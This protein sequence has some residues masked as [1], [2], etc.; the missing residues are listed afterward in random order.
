MSITIEKSP[1]IREDHEF[2][3]QVTAATRAALRQVHWSAGQLYMEVQSLPDGFAL[4]DEW[5]RA[6]LGW[7]VNRLREAKHGLIM[8]GLY[9]WED[10]HDAEGQLR[11]ACRYLTNVIRE[12]AS[13]QVKP[14]GG[15]ATVGQPPQIP[16]V[17]EKK[18]ERHGLRLPRLAR[19]GAP[20]DPATCPREAANQACRN[21]AA[22][23]AD[24]AQPEKPTAATH[25][26]PRP[27]H[28]VIAV[29]LG[30]TGTECEHGH[31][32]SRCGNCRARAAAA[33]SS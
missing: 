11:R 21:C 27:V 10:I 17:R 25:P 3:P 8:A 31:L 19:P 33:A 32:P 29:A 9:V 13:P 23:V 12:A 2:A 15:V 5:L 16:P 28:E 6:R 1:V 30:Q 24:H 20:H 18:R 14:S 22:W 26:A 4:A 7:T